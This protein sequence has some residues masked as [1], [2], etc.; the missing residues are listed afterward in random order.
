V[1]F[2]F[3]SVSASLGRV[4]RGWNR[5][6]GTEGAGDDVDADVGVGLAYP[7]LPRSGNVERNISSSSMEVG[8]DPSIGARLR[9]RRSWR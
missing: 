7:P 5:F 4:T 1:I 6:C 2:S 9:G 8:K 3:L